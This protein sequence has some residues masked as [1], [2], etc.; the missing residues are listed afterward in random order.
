[1][2]DNSPITIP[3]RA[4]AAGAEGAAAG[5]VRPQKWNIDFLIFIQ[6]SQADFPT[7]KLSHYLFFLCLICLIPFFHLN[8]LKVYV[9]IVD[10]L[11]VIL[12]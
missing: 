2:R 12:L 6:L 3:V 7:T 10:P 9:G 8:D 4:G 1:M 5:A 11:T